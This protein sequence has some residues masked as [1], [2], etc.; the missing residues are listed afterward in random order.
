MEYFALPHTPIR[1]VLLPLPL[2]GQPI[3]GV[4]R[5]HYRIDVLSSDHRSPSEAISRRLGSEASATRLPHGLYHHTWAEHHGSEASKVALERVRH[6]LT[7]F[8]R[9]HAASRRSGP[10]RTDSGRAPL[11]SPAA[12][13][14]DVLTPLHFRRCCA[15]HLEPNKIH[16]GRETPESWFTSVTMQSL[17][18]AG[19][20]PRRESVNFAI[21]AFLPPAFPSCTT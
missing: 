13:C 21:S 11:G 8:V 12:R 16:H 1:A 5:C 18:L 14:Q 2:D 19:W 10:L 7:P 4:G 17:V 9:S 20:R 15:C 6:V 3:Y